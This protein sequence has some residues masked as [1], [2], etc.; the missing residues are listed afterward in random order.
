MASAAQTSQPFGPSD[1][2]YGAIGAFLADHRLSVDPVNYTFAHRL[3]SQPKGPLAAAVARVTDGGVR[4]TSRDIEDMGFQA[5]AAGATVARD[6]ADDDDKP[7]ESP[8]AMMQALVARTQMQVEDFADTV[9]TMR[10]ETQVF[11]RDLLAG[12]DAIRSASGATGEDITRM[13][14]TMLDRVQAAEERLATATVEAEAL[15]VELEAA[16]DDARRDPLTGLANRRA[17][18]DAFAAASEENVPICIALCDID[19]FKSVNDRFGHAVGDRVLKAIAE[20]LREACGEHLVARYGGEE[21]AILFTGVTVDAAVATLDGARGAVA[22]KRY[23]LRETDAPLGA[24][25]FS[26]GVS[27]HEAGEVMGSVM[28]RADR[29]LYAAKHAGRNQIKAGGEKSQLAA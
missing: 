3:L 29:L 11:G 12:A 14:T 23:R 6:D 22:A 4:L 7:T 5:G 13:A 25:T 26:G 1:R 24:V 28:G 19:R 2:L 21:F 18:E 15:R 10:A 17:L 8:N 27:V 9:A 20:A 16:R